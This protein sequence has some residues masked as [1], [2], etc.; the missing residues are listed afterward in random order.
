MYDQNTNYKYNH[1]I[2]KDRYIDYNC[3]IIPGPDDG[4][5][6]LGVM[7]KWTLRS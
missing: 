3:R 2:R 4:C 1:T 5:P 6:I 7:I